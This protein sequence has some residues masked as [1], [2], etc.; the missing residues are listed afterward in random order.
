MIQVEFPTN[1]HSEDTKNAKFKMMSFCQK[2]QYLHANVQGVY[3]LYAKYQ[4]L[5]A[6]ALLQVEFPLYALYEPYEEEK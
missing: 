2:F 1:A 5:R 3:I 6:K 4:V